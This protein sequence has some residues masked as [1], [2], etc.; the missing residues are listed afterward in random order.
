MY[1]YRLLLYCIASIVTFLNAPNLFD[2]NYCFGCAGLYLLIAI[3]SIFRERKKS[4]WLN[5]S[6]IFTVFLFITSFLIPLALFFDVTYI[7]YFPYI[8][9]ATALCPLALCFYYIGRSIAFSK[10]TS[11]NFNF[12][13]TKKMLI[14]CNLLTIIVMIT[15]LLN[16][17]QFID[18]SDVSSNDIEDRYMVTFLY[19]IPPLALLLS[20]FYYKGRIYGIKSFFIC[21]KIILISMFIAI[22]T[23]LYIGDRTI[24]LYLVLCI[25][26]VYNKFVK[27][28]KLTFVI[29]LALCCGSLFYAIGQT[30]K[31]ESAIREVG[32]SGILNYNS[33]DRNIINYFSDFYPSSEAN[34][35]F[36]KWREDHGGD[37]YYPSKIF[38]YMVAPIPFV[39]S[40]FSNVFYGVPYTHLSSGYLS[41]N[42]YRQ[43]VRNIYGG[44]GTHAVGDIYVSWGVVGIII[45][46]L[47]L[48]YVAGK[49][50]LNSQVNIYSAL[51]YMSLFADAIYMA[52]AS[53]FDCYRTIIFQI[54]IYCLIKQFCVRR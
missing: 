19:S 36:V 53:L 33:F 35:L 15:Y 8:C 21:N 9:K 25:I 5:F 28:V 41:T 20:T 7:F 48:G 14:I 2:Y 17:Q 34:Y 47:L 24:P 38:L 4:G 50:Y 51:I 18:T 54:I 12:F 31:G 29:I 44:I 52:R 43:F 26:F 32:I 40:I 13:V 1:K 45:L 6:I 11:L 46:F 10:A 30:R 22:L 37:L 27:P 16:F 39:P 42:L 49:S 3:D 23:S